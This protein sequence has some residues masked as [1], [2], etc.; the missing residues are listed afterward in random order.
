VNIGLQNYN[1]R[2][3][4]W[5]AKSKGYHKQKK[6]EQNPPLKVNPDALYDTLYQERNG[7]LPL[8][9]RVALPELVSVLT[10]GAISIFH[11]PFCNIIC[12]KCG[13]LMDSCFEQQLS[14]VS[15]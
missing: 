9:A 10:E 12:G 2:R 7:P 11:F 4:K 15:L 13:K 8:S 14:C 5:N 6:I 1:M 3:M